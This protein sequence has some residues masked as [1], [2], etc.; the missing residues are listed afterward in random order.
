MAY[1]GP[2]ARGLIGSVAAGLLQSHS[3]A[4]SE[5]CLQP[6]PQLTATLGPQATEQASDQTHNL[7]VLSRIH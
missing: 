6:A 1:G 7:I 2:Q 3:N 5:P 4:G